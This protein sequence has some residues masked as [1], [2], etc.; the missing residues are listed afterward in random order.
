MF[1]SA[2][3]VNFSLVLL[4]GSLQQLNFY[5][6]YKRSVKFLTRGFKLILSIPTSQKPLIELVDHR[7]MVNKLKNFG[8][9]GTL[10][11]W[12]EDYLSNRHQRVTVLGKTSHPLHILTGIPQRSILGPLLFP[13]YVNRPCSSNIFIFYCNVR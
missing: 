11:N 12:F 4:G 2:F 6:S 8:I 7:L 3:N 13:L 10:L 1:Q 5:K 9:S